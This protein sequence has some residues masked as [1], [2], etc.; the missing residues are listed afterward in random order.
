MRIVEDKENQSDTLSDAS[1]YSGDIFDDI[2]FIRLSPWRE[3]NRST[4]LPG[5]ESCAQRIFRRFSF[6][7]D[8]DVNL[9]FWY[10]GFPVEEKTAENFATLL[11]SNRQLSIHDLMPV[12]EVL[13]VAGEGLYKS[14]SNRNIEI[15]IDDA[16]IGRIQGNKVLAVWWHWL[17]GG[18]SRKFLSIFTDTNRDGNVHE[19]HFSAPES[20]MADFASIITD[21]I[22]SFQWRNGCTPPPLSSGQALSA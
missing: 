15:V 22:R 10:R 19:I 3:C 9:D 4:A 18:A 7:S 2:L 1:K 21:T 6:Y 20:K 11:E 13:G 14:G 12:V 5:L 8:P 17:D 16:E